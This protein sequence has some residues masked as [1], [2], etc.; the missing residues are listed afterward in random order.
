MKC[1]FRYEKHLFQKKTF[2]WV[3]FIKTFLWVYFIPFYEKNRCFSF[4]KNE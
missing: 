3:Y 2:L 1:F 4:H